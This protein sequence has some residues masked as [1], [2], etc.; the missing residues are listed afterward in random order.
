M[1]DNIMEALVEFIFGGK[2][3]ATLIILASIYL[4]YNLT[5]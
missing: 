3:V 4:I 2:L 1:L 5:T